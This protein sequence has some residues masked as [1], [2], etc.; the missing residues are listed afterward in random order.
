MPAGD[1]KQQLTKAYKIINDI[2]FKWTEK[3]KIQLLTRKMS[4][5][6]RRKI[7]TEANNDPEDADKWTY[8]GL[9]ALIEKHAVTTIDSVKLARD[10]SELI[11]DITIDKVNENI[12]KFLED[13]E[14][15]SKGVES[16]KIDDE[17]R[18]EA[19]E[20][21][22]SDRFKIQFKSILL[23][24]SLSQETG[25]ELRTFKIGTNAGLSLPISELLDFVRATEQKKQGKQE[26]VNGVY[27]GKPFK[28]R[29]R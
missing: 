29:Q 2:R 15:S 3:L 11:K 23:R 21:Y 1:L 13:L 6:L 27:Q 14:H 24:H 26:T 8:E 5:E 22:I 12:E 28:G 16:N 17:R 9:V 10:M 4:D 19:E 20:M 18:K 7:K 25:R